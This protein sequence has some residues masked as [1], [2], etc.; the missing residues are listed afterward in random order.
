MSIMGNMTG[1]Y[2]PM[3]KTFII[4]DLN[5]NEVVGVVT[6]QEQVFTAT[7]NDVREGMVYASDGGV[8]IGVKNIPSY[9]TRYGC[10]VI[11]SG[12][13]AIIPT[14]EYDFNNLFVIIAVYDTSIAKSVLST[15]ILIDG[16][17]YEVGSSTK[18]SDVS[19]DQINKEIDLGLIMSEKSVIRYL[20]TREEF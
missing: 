11:A 10:R 14:P 3:G 15:Y 4:E 5:G 1:C 16:G 18:L 7:D 20:V 17:M 6:D 9:H 2:S 12:K 19:V 8:S 13:N